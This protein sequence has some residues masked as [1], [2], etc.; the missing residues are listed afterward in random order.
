MWQHQNVTELFNK[1]RD[2]AFQNPEEKLF[3]S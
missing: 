3:P 2:T 1:A